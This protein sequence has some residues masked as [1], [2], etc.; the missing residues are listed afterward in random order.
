VEK[1]ETSDKKRGEKRKRANRAM[2]PVHR[3]RER[4]RERERDHGRRTRAHKERK[5]ERENYREREREREREHGR[6]THKHIVTDTV[7]F[8]DFFLKKNLNRS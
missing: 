6:R 2:R 8:S 7:F 5:R 1:R 3:D 4:E